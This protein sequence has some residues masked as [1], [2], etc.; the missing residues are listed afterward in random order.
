MSD[1]INGDVVFTRIQSPPMLAHANCYAM[2]ECR[3]VL[4]VEDNLWHLSISCPDRDPTWDEIATARYRLAPENV[5][6]AM[7]LPPMREYVN[8]HEH[9]FHLYELTKKEIQND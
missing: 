9:V 3:V 8:L 4:A 6:M 7:L 1:R 2:G 5:T